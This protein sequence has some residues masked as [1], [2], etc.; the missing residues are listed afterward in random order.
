VESL[1]LFI[2]DNNRLWRAGS[3]SSEIIIG[4]G[5]PAVI[6]SDGQL[7]ALHSLLLTLMNNCRFSTA[8]YYL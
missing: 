3:C 4:C 5:E 8:Y 1:Q 2:R 7:Q 6:I